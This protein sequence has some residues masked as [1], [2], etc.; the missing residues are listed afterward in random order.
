MAISRR[1]FFKKMAALTAA[2]TTMGI[3]E[4]IARAASIA[5][6][7]GTTYLDAEHVVILM[8]ENRSF[9]HIYGT[10]R[11][12]RGFNDPRAYRLPNGNP[13][14]LQTDADGETFAPWRLDINNTKITWMGSLPHPRNSQVDA[15]DLG[16]HN[17]WIDAKR[18]S[19]AAYSRMPITMGHYTRQDIPFYYALADAFTVC[20]HNFCGVMSSTDPNRLIFMTGTVR[21]AQTDTAKANMRNEDI[22]TGGASWTTFPELLEAAGVSWKCYQNAN[23]YGNGLTDA[24]DAWLGNYTPTLEKFAQ[25]HIKSD[26]SKLTG[27][28]LDLYNRAFGTN[29]GDPNY[30]TLDVLNYTDDT[31]TARSFSLPKGDVLY[32]FRQDVQNGSLPTVSWLSSAQ[33]YSG[34]PSAPYY[35]AWYVSE[36]MSILTANPD[37][38]KKTIFILT[39]DE[40]DGY[41]DHIPPFVCPNPNDP[42]TGAASTGIDTALEFVPYAQDLANLVSSDSSTLARQGPIGLGYRVPMIIASPW[43]RGGWVNSQVF[44]HSSTLQFLEKFCSHKSGTTIKSGNI[45]AWR[46]TVSGDLTSNFRP[47]N[48]ETM[49]ALLFLDRDAFS[50]GIYSAQYKH[51]PTNFIKLTAG[52]IADVLANPITSQYLTRQESGIKPACANL[53]ELYAEGAL[54]AD[55]KGFVLSVSAGNSIFGSQSLGGAFNAISYGLSTAPTYSVTPSYSVQLTYGARIPPYSVPSSYA[56]TPGDTLTQSYVLTTFNNGL[57]HVR[58]HGPNGFFRMFMGNAA[59]PMLNV[60]MG[61]SAA[62]AAQKVVFT[63][64]ATSSTG[65]PYTVSIVDNSYQAAT[66]HQVIDPAQPGATVLALDVS[67]YYGWYDFSVVVSGYSSF[68]RRYAGHVENGSDSYTDPLMGGVI[69]GITNSCV[70]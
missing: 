10:L 43:S 59:D 55:K 39:H 57:Y 69:Q 12:V 40:N 42:T 2:A 58:V 65:S 26:P 15:W 29:A 60:S 11:G 7:P 36:I 28:S 18:S 53:Y 22:G 23:N 34:H 46:R 21:S 56:V 17:D 52:Q 13:V 68:T 8:Q 47:Y 20:D 41:F 64:T 1:E 14:W 27:T 24:Q 67:R 50:E 16:L 32:Q 9:E 49:A 33:N 5:P 19:S 31:G 70:A 25:F 3:P 62:G 66:V 30:T 37:V 63:L 48:G 61:Y 35:A 44:D 4:S 54:S 45:S 51:V 38:W 6:D